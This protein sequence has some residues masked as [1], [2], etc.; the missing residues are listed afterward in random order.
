MQTG[1]FKNISQTHNVQDRIVYK[2]FCLT[3]IK[4]EVS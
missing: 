2:D 3:F 4:P 1:N